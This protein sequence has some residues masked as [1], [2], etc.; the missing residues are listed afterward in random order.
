[1]NY[2]HIPKQK[3]T[4]LKSPVETKTQQKKKRI[5]RI[6]IKINDQINIHT[7]KIE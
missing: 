7:K 6:R 4:P 3:Q 2:E 1:M 5:N